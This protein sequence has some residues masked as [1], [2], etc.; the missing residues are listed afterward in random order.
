MRIRLISV[1]VDGG[2]NW[3]PCG[4]SISICS[5]C[6]FLVCLE[7][8]WLNN[9]WSCTFQELRRV[10]N[11]IRDISCEI[12]WPDELRVSRNL[13]RKSINKWIIRPADK[14]MIAF[15]FIEPFSERPDFL[16]FIPCFCPLLKR[17]CWSWLFSSCRVWRRVI[18]PCTLWDKSINLNCA[19]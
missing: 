7:C 2:G 17:P 15:N 8:N 16:P 19:N 13:G 18:R 3:I 11:L 14:I 5:L 12:A 4:R 9:S 1:F 10:F 6:A